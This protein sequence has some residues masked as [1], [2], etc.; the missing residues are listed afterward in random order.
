[1][2]KTKKVSIIIMVIAFCL[3]LFQDVYASILGDIFSK[4]GAFFS[5]GY[6]TGKTDPFAV[7]LQ[8]SLLADGG[9]VDAIKTVG[10]LVF[11]ITGAVLGIKYMWSG[12][13]GKVFAKEGLVTYSIGVVFFYLAD[14]IYTF[15]KKIL[16]DSWSTSTSFSSASGKIWGTVS[17]VIS[18][19]CVA[20]V[21]IYGIKY[22]WS[23]ANEKAG[24][25]KGMIPLIIGAILITCT[26]NIMQFVVN[27]TTNTI[28]NET[29]Y[30]V[31][32]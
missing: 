20:T 21:V 29:T 11:F 28:G 19:L 22:M 7:S 2:K 32:K 18:T 17:A 25:K 6:N 3:I 26:V 15:A 9:I 13:E 1:M 4:G 27:V 16:I 10:Y 14:Q 5:G 12:V 30:Q 23:S 24:M 8:Q 31:T